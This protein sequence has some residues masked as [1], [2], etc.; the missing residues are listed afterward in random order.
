MPPPKVPLDILLLI[1]PLL[2]DDDGKLC[3]A[4]FNSF[5]KV[6]R[7]LYD[8]L[9][10]T[11]W[12]KA[13]ACRS[14]TKH[15]FEHIIH[16]NDVKSLK[17]FLELGAEVETRLLRYNNHTGFSLHFL[18]PV[19]I[20][21]AQL[22]NVEMAHML[23]HHGASMVQ[24]DWRQRPGHSALHAA[25]SAEMVQ[26]LLIHSADP[27]LHLQA[28]LRTRPLHEY[29]ARGYIEAMRVALAN[30][31]Q[32]DPAG[33]RL[34]WT[35]LH[36][37]AGR[38]AGAVKLLLEHG[39]DEQKRDAQSNTALHLAAKAGYTDAMRLLMESW[40]DGIRDKGDYENT[41]LHFA[42]YYGKT[43]AL[44]LLI[45]G[46]PQGMKEK[47]TE[48]GT[49]LHLAAMRGKTDAARVLV[50][51]W[52][53]GTRERDIFGNTPL[54]NAAVR[55]KLGMVMLLLETWP[56]SKGALNNS[57]QTA[58][59]VFLTEHEEPQPKRRQEIL[60]LLGGTN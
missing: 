42:A 47:D 60:A 50:E 27:E 57:G 36:Y 56:E 12:K 20:T 37:A 2:T 33:G 1:P 44:R 16:T 55:G 30:G 3:F 23:L 40:P 26:L 28:T 54:H 22:N 15:V 46:W 53:H 34:S 41:P 24:Y 59:A 4:D 14:T 7:A 45:E 5:L 38:S 9:N 18:Q 11:L 17:F 21:T 31:V 8:C 48:G 6:N 25:C 51:R 29:S 19:L 13:V 39:A 32:V 49:P 10:R 35:P 58:L 43:D 52:P